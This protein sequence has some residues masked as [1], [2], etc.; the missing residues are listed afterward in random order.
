MKKDENF[1]DKTK[2]TSGFPSSELN[3]GL[4]KNNLPDWNRLYSEMNV[5]DMPWYLDELDPD[6]KDA[7]N[8]YHILSGNFLDLGTGPGTQAIGL[9][10]LGFEVTDAILKARQLNDQVIF[11]QDDILNSNLGQHFEYVFDRG[12]F[13]IID[14]DK[15][16]VYISAVLKLLN[17]NGILFLKCFS[18]KNAVTGFGPHH[19][20]KSVIESLFINQFDILQ[21]KDSFYNS[22]SS[23]QKKTWFV[24]MKKK[25]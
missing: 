19:I 15:R 20:S 25:N 24:V 8:E 11:I 17:K 6:L 1:K 3:D 2:D 18:D 16:S 22:K 23:N 14:K 21:I 9:S 5:Q 7:L 12:C 13:H 10:K 4:T